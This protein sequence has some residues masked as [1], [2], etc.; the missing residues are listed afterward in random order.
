M[1]ATPAENVSLAVPLL[2]DRGVADWPA[3]L[4]FQIP[5]A[6]LVRVI[7]EFRQLTGKDVSFAW[8]HNDDN[9]VFIVANPPI[10]WRERRME[11]A[12][13]DS[14]VR[15]FREW[16]SGVWLELGFVPESPLPA[17]FLTRPPHRQLL[18]RSPGELLEIGSL[19][20]DAPQ[21]SLRLARSV[22]GSGPV[23]DKFTLTPRM[24]RRVAHDPP[25]LW[26]I[27]KD[28]LAQLSRHCRTAGEQTLAAFEVAVTAMDGTPAVLVRCSSS[29]RNLPVFVANAEAYVSWQKRSNLFLPQGRRL[30]PPL[31]RDVVL[32]TLN[33][34][35]DRIY[36]MAETGSSWRLES[37]PVDSFHPLSKW[38]E[39]RSPQAANVRTVW[40]QSD[41]W[42]TETFVERTEPERERRTPEPERTNQRL[43]KE[44]KKKGLLARAVDWLKAPGKR[45]LADV[46]EEPEEIP[47]AEAV[48]TALRQSDRLHHARPDGPGGISER[49]HQLEMAFFRR[50]EKPDGDLAA[51]WTELATAYDAA[52]K[53]SDAALCWLNALWGDRAS[54]P[55]WAWGWLR[56]AARDAHLDAKLADPAE[57]LAATPTAN[58]TRA[59]AAWV[60][61]ASRQSP[62]SE[63]L[64]RRAVELQ[65][66]LRAN[67]HWL[68]VRAAWLAQGALAKFNRGDVLALARTRDRLAERLLG[69]GLSLELDTPPFLRFGDEESRN[70]HHEASRW[71]E[72]KRRPIRQWI[73]GLASKPLVADK[74]SIPSGILLES[75]LEPER[76]NTARYVDLLIG[77]GLTRLSESLR[78]EA[79]IKQAD[80]GFPVADPV[81]GLIR[82]AFEHRLRNLRDGR[83]AR[84]PLPPEW[85]ARR[86]QLPG[87]ERYFADKFFESSRVL[88]PNPPPSAYL[89]AVFQKARQTGPTT[90]T[91]NR[92]NTAALNER[93]PDILQR[94]VSQ[95]G[96][97]VEL[98]RLAGDALRRV[99]ELQPETIETLFGL[100]PTALD[101]TR[102]APVE[103][104]GLIEHGLA[105]ASYA[106]RPDLARL[107]VQELLSPAKAPAGPDLPEAMTSQAFRSLRRM[108]LKTEADR[109]LHH[110]AGNVTQG[111]SYSKLRKTRPMEW[112]GLLRT[113]LH[114]AA[115]WYYAG[116]DEQAYAVLEEAKTDLYDAE[117]TP[118]NR[119]RLAMAYVQTLGQAPFRVALGR[120]D[121]MFQRL[122]GLHVRGTANR[123]FCL[124]ALQ[125]VEAG[126]RAVVADD[127][128]AG[129]GVRA[130]LDTDEF[131][132]RQRI[133]DELAES[134]KTQGLA[135]M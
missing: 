70:R 103:W 20:V 92:L 75:G 89:E 111:M 64:S 8:L 45:D 58:L 117:T 27:T 14:R 7:G 115:G 4:L 108:G 34:L 12:R 81:H 36:W 65:N 22:L 104:A 105:A 124:P 72:E 62:T 90:F 30:E 47:V 10:I 74:N 94:E 9:A 118:V 11:E 21:L 128:A 5:G 134:M 66:H 126:V 107:F 88:Q 51:A 84:L 96:A 50:I 54:P 80:E 86:E 119:T 91:L 121:E 125:L 101:A 123:Y 82:E 60:V 33:M 79:V 120:L 93:L 98:A 130:W 31:R 56:A 67:E 73:T 1:A 24:S 2:P 116:R 3:K 32:D 46:S 63:G 52:E 42:V 71:L 39:Y 41:D 95:R 57:W 44:A 114:V 102:S 18:I 16:A 78:G 23:P 99:T 129:P 55:L 131:S 112:P 53:P 133:R 13:R 97:T 35:S 85:H 113:M 43:A 29:L 110:L 122:S 6:D 38:V 76:I 17:S 15:V 83:S 59:L 61:W 87:M 77:W 37:V 40:E 26:I 100:L 69:A 109:V 25:S 28:A 19:P 48:R 135:G 132:V 68:P 106:D 49:C 127:L